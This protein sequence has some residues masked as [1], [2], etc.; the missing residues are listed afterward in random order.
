MEDGEVQL[1]RL[2]DALDDV[3]ERRH[4]LSPHRSYRE[5][6]GWSLP[7]DAAFG[8]LRLE[9]DLGEARAAGPD[10]A[11]IRGAHWR[12]FLVKYSESNRMHKKMQALSSL[13]RA[14]GVRR[15][16]PTG[17]RAGPVQRRVLARCLRR[18]LPA[19][20]SR[21]DLAQPGG[22]RGD[23]SGG[24]RTGVGRLDFDGDGHEEIWIH[25]AASRRS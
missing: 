11:L 8:S 9:R 25:S 1:S 7:P 12:N 4:R 19:P 20:P 14:R 21:C 22:R 18:A 13:C 17:H 6:E 24:R 15:G 2:D 10:G 3:P 23:G 16:G 5:M